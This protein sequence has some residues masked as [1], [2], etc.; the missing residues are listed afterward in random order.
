V[1]VLIVQFGDDHPRRETV[2][3]ILSHKI[4][5][6]MTIN[7]QESKKCKINKLIEMTSW[8]PYP[9]NLRHNNAIDSLVKREDDRT[10]QEGLQE[11]VG[12]HR[13]DE[14][15]PHASTH[16]AQ[17]RGHGE[18]VELGD[19]HVDKGARVDEEDKQARGRDLLIVSNASDRE[20]NSK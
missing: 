7:K 5:D 8:L 1:D 10:A 13:E 3:D 17:A 9:I 14:V 12:H 18:V 20:Q 15:V 4:E 2:K 16:D 6:Q 11:D 19:L